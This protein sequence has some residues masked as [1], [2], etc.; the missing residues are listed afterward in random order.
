MNFFCKT[1]PRLPFNPQK[2]SGLS[3]GVTAARRD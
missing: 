2:A 3:F 1:L